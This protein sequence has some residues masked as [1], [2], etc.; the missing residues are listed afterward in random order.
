M[1]AAQLDIYRTAQKEAMSG[2]EIEAL[3]LTR[4][5]LQLRKCQL[6]WDPQDREGQRSEALSLNQR[7]WTILQGELAKEDNPLPLQLRRDLLSLSVFVDKRTF[8]VMAHP[9]KEKL[10]ML[11]KIN[12][13][14]AAG[15][16]SNPMV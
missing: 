16:R 4:A 15:L 11:I 13:N 14:L 1:Y 3:A 9:A 12:L 6:E 5:A 8:E 10:T 2:R 7:I